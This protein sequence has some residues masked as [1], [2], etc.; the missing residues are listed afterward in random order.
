M[1]Q[2]GISPN[3]PKS[4]SR[5]RELLW[6]DVSD[7][8]AA[9]T[10]ARNGMYASFFVAGATALL[11]LFSILPRASLIDGVLFLAVGFGIRQMWRA[12]AIA[13]LV[14][15]LL[16]QG[17]AISHGMLGSGTLVAIIVTAIFIG[18]VRATWAYPKLKLQ[19]AAG[20][21]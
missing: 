10:A 16:E 6:P 5:F 17:F 3:A 19:E 14:L 4:N 21:L 18:A 12:A 8:I 15:Y 13:G 9:E 20:P 1:Q 7:L 2:L 11:A